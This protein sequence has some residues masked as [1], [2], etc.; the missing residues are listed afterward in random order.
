VVGDAKLVGSAQVIEGDTLLQHGSILLDDDQSRIAELRADPSP[1][2]LG[3]GSG[4]SRHAGA[5]NGSGIGL[6]PVA[7]LRAALR[8]EVSAAEVTEAIA[9]V[10]DDSVTSVRVAESDEGIS[11]SVAAHRARFTDPGWTWRR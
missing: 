11:A 5:A 6:A 9:G 7:T 2:A 1:V 8:R 4:S 10:L 3:V